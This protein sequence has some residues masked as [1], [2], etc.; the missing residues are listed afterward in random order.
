M[1]YGMD[2]LDEFGLIKKPK[3]NW[4]KIAIVVAIILLCICLGVATFFYSY[5]IINSNQDNQDNLNGIGAENTNQKLKNEERKDYENIDIIEENTINETQNKYS[6]AHIKIPNHNMDIIKTQ[7]LPKMNEN[8]YEEIKQLYKSDEK[9]IYLTF[10]DGPSR[11]VTPKILDILKE[12]DVKATFF[13]LGSRVELYPDTLKREFEEGHYIANHGY[14]HEYSQIYRSKDTVFEEY[15]NC[16][17][18][19]KNALNNQNYSSYLFRFPGG[20]SGGRY[21]NI[22][23]EARDLFKTYGI[24]FTNWNCLTGDAENSKT[25]EQCIQRMLDTRNNQNS[26]VLLMH[27]A[28][29]KN[30]TVEALPDIIQYFKN[31]GYTFKNF[32]DIFR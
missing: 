8:A 2:E 5:K 18:A 29:D 4:K 22:K 17:I 24:A 6:K 32:Y 26:I 21:E 15:Y 16:E 31:D 11:D 3:L 1:L 19:I 7:F 12:Y 20:S 30:Q 9:Q 23:A 28:N 25:K 27:D 13:V 10:D 14:S